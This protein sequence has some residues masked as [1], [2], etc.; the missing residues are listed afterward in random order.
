MADCCWWWF[1]CCS[2]AV[3]EVGQAQQQRQQ[4]EQYQFVPVLVPVVVVALRILVVV[5]A[6]TA[7]FQR[8]LAS[9]M[10]IG[11]QQ[12]GKDEAMPPY[13]QQQEHQL[14]QYSVLF[15]DYYRH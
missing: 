8:A 3:A 7:A 6:L 13:L 9:S 10:A 2:G 5:V 12:E 15:V 14:Q 1:Y 4:Q 11:D